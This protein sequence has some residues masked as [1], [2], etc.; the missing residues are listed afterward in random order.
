M[1]AGKGQA[2]VSP[3]E[4]LQPLSW[5]WRSCV[6]G[7]HRAAGIRPE[8]QETTQLWGFAFSSGWVTAWLGG[9]A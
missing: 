7:P 4:I 8:N 3:D 9:V 2:V 5:F 1:R 6:S